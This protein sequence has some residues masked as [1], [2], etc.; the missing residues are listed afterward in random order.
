LHTRDTISVWKRSETCAIVFAADKEEDSPEE[1]EEVEYRHIPLE[2]Q[3][4]TNLATSCLQHLLLSGGNGTVESDTSVVLIASVS[5][6]IPS[7]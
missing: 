7:V 3:P 2:E 4:S 5:W 1:D 6:L